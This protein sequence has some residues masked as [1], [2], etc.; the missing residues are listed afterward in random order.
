MKFIQKLNAHHR[1]KVGDKLVS[2]E[3]LGEPYN[4]TWENQ[5]V[6]LVK[7]NRN[8]N[9]KAPFIVEPTFPFLGVRATP[10]HLRRIK[11]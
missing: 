3:F 7:I 10:I 4:R 5:V 1:F 9:A 8:P 11:S 2:H 6:K